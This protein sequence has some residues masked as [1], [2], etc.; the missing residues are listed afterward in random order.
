MKM[1]MNALYAALSGA[2]LLGAATLGAAQTTNTTTGDSTSPSAGTMHR[3][4]APHV[5][6]NEYKAEKSRISANYKE[7]AA[8]CKAMKGNAKEV[9]EKQAKA[10]EKIAK[11]ELESKHKGKDPATDYKVAETRAKANYDVAQ[12]KCDDM[13]GKEKSACKKQAKA[14]E[15]RA[16]AEAKQMRKQHVASSKPAK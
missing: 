2:F 10:D 12:E 8:K 5:A 7:A 1:K 6:A 15:D 16:L 11:A 3:A 14:D 13:K 9:C 4:T